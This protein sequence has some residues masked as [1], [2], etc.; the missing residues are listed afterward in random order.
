MS[1]HHV[2]ILNILNSDDG[3]TEMASR[4]REFND[5]FE[6]LLRSS[7]IVDAEVGSGVVVRLAEDKS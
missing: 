5:E 6:V 1:D 3:I 7:M 2:K 4:L